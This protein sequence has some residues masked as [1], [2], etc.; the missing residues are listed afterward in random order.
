MGFFFLGETLGAIEITG[1]ILILVGGYIIV[2]LKSK[3]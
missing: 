1:G 3:K 2:M